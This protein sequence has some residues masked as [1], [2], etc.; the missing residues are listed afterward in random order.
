MDEP[1]STESVLSQAFGDASA[2]EPVE[3]APTPPAAQTEPVAQ[4]PV[5]PESQ[6]GPSIDPLVTRFKALGAS[7]GDL[8]MVRRHHEGFLRSREAAPSEPV[9]PWKM[10]AND[11]MEQVNPAERLEHE[12]Y[13]QRYGDQ[14]YVAAVHRAGQVEPEPEP[15][16]SDEDADFNKRVAEAVARALKPYEPALVETSQERARSRLQKDLD[17][18]LDGLKVPEHARDFLREDIEREVNRVARVSPNTPLSHIVNQRWNALQPVL[19]S[20]S[21]ATTE[22]LKASTKPP[23]QPTP[24]P[25]TGERMREPDTSDEMTI[26][27]RLGPAFKAAM[28]AAPPEGAA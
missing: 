9:D 8:E 6:T 3:P 26:E 12:Q 27:G 23:T 1:A 2:N 22:N 25:P 18:L 7:D 19:D 11:L 28:D 16:P 10:A 21:K 15:E 14:A 17:P 4:P 13:R 5:T 24:T 20:Q